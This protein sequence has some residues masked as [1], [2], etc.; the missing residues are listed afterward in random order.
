MP[1]PEGPAHLPLRMRGTH[2]VKALQWKSPV[3][4][5]QV[6][7]A[8]LLAGLY[9]SGVTE[10]LE[11]TLSRDH[12]ERMLS[13]SGVPVERAGARVYSRNGHR[14]RETIF[15]AQRFIERRLLSGGRAC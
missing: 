9:A 2:S 11:P 13:A 6:K 1:K 4:S 3:A 8:I 5:A 7:S 12:T 15:G 14:S 10:V